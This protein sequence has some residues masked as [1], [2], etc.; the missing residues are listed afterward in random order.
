MG[1]R[2]ALRGVAL[3]EGA[4]GALILLAGVGALA[5]VHH[6]VQRVAEQLVG[7]LHLNPAK[8]YPR[9][10]IDSAA[11][12]TDAHLWMLAAFAA[13]YCTIRFAE[14]YGLWHGRRWAEWLAAGSGGPSLPVE[15]YELMQRG[16][17]IAP[18]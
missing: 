9:I 18:A 1:L 14:A 17:P 13:A 2:G 15:P 5:L 10:F 3:F 11:R 4:K 8:H 16:N 12:L 7:H 6:D